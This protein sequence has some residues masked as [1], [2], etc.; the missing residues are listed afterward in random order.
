MKKQEL[1]YCGLDCAECPVFIATATDDEELR[2]KT[3]KE[4]SKLYAAQLAEYAGKNELE[5]EDMNCEGCH[6]EGDHFIGCM[7]CPIRKCGQDK[8]ITTCAGCNEYGI[9]DM[10]NGFFTLHQHA[11]ENLDRMRM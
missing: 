3:A 1:A 9:C 4:W 11:K 5:P 8:K 10:L 7:Y 6:S 2:Q